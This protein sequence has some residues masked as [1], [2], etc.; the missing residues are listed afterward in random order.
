MKIAIDIRE[1]TGQKT[2]KGWYTYVMV[3]NVLKLDTEN[4]YILYTHKHNR[5]FDK[6]KNAKQRI[7]KSGGLKWHWKVIKDLKK[8]KP[9]LFWA[10]TS[11]IIPAFAPKGM[12]VILTIHDLIAFLFPMQHNKKAVL[13]ER[14]M[15]PRAIKRATKISTVSYNT[16][17]D[18][19]RKF[20]VPTKK[21]FIAPCGASKIFRPIPDP[22]ERRKIQKKYNLPE[23][24]I[25]GVGTLSPRKNFNRLIQAYE[26]IADK[27]PDTDLVIVGDKG[28][29]F[30]RTVKQSSAKERVHLV[31]YVG[32]N[33]IAV[34]YNMAEIFVFPSL[35][36]G[37]GMPPLEAMACGCPVITSNLS[38]LPEVVGKAALLIDPYSVPD[39]AAS[40]EKI[41]TN[42]TLKRELIEKGF[43]QVKK[44]MW[45]ESA[46]KLVDTFN[47]KSHGKTNKN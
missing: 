25:L 27:H 3:K 5:K 26:Q 30:E 47:Q 6:Y 29:N 19:Q 16:K 45:E 7:I 13:L 14:M 32:G 20:N 33:E 46:K 42:P 24:F 22:I 44:F 31:G 9:D 37:F 15:V 43:E 11:Y 8:K 21:T 41:L 12:K 39:I 40:M 35:Y 1:T 18:I 23:K 38:S 28:W 36:E 2:G 10:P 17:R 4:E 34:L